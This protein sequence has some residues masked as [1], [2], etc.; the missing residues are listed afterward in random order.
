MGVKWGGLCRVSYELESLA[1]GG[2]PGAAVA[3]GLRTPCSSTAPAATRQHAQQRVPSSRLP[4]LSRHGEVLWE[5]KGV[6]SGS[7]RAASF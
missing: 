7:Q 4:L 2:F 1:R 5:R 3:H 6:G